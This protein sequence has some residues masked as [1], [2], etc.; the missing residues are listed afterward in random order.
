MAATVSEAKELVSRLCQQFYSQGWVSGTGG[1]ISIRVPSKHCFV[2]APSGVQKERLSSEDMYVISDVDGSVIEAPVQKP[3]PARA[4]KCSECLPLLTSAF[5]LRNANAVLHSHS[6]E[7]VMVTLLEADSTEFRCTNLEMI[8]GIKGH[9]YA[10]ML[11]VPIIENT[12]REHELVHALRKAILKYPRSNAV[13]VRRHGVYIWG[14][15]WISA[16]TQAECYHYLFQ[17]YVEARKFNIDVSKPLSGTSS[18]GGIKRK[19][20]EKLNGGLAHAIS[21]QLTSTPDPPCAGLVWK[22]GFE[23][24]D[25]S[26]PLFE[27]VPEALRRWRSKGIKVY[28]YSSGSRYAQKLLLSHS[29]QGDVSL[30]IDGYFDVINSGL[31]TEKS[32]FFDIALTLGLYDKPSSILFYTDTLSEYYAATEAGWQARWIYRLGNKREE[33][34]PNRPSQVESLDY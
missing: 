31:K 19:K 33:N 14:D 6:I 15:D 27:D 22:R 11:V 29:M 30:C 18:A 21:S 7:S 23:V 12:P 32:S 24:G 34:S 26:C 5:E 9:G 2:V 3:W 13:L 8:K 20:S 17:A 16:K 10:D 1:G 28:M 4:V 25:L